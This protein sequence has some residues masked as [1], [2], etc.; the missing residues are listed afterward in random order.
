MVDNSAALERGLE[1]AKGIILK[2]MTDG[3]I[4]AAHNFCADA[5]RAYE[6]PLMG[7]TGNTWTGTAVGA[8]VSGKLIYYTTTKAVAGMKSAKRVKLTKGEV[9]YLKEDY[10]G[11]ERTFVGMTET[12]K[13]LSE[14]DA[15]EF[16]KSHRHTGKYALTVVNGSEYANYIENQMSGNVLMKTYFWSTELLNVSFERVKLN[17]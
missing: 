11:R 16:L 17:V 12:D 6:S 14:Y 1:K 4:V 8:Y 15:I 10:L 2:R 3:L 7:F 13:R 9:A 5:F